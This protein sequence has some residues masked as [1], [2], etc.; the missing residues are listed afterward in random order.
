MLFVSIK[1]RV[2]AGPVTLTN[3]RARSGLVVTPDRWRDRMS[4]PHSKYVRDKIATLPFTSANRKY[5]G[6][7]LQ[8]ERMALHGVGSYLG[9]MLDYSLRARYP[10]EY[11]AIWRELNPAQY[12]RAEQKRARWEQR[13]REYERRE[14][15]REQRQRARD[16][17]MWQRI[18]TTV[19]PTSR[20]EADAAPS[21][22]R[23]RKRARPSGS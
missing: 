15:A 12:E 14:I 21:E 19:R 10:T 17:E 5:V 18:S 13:R 1:T 20:S 23:R 8:I 7:L 2:G 22:P 3:S 16:R 4:R 11:A 9:G 6:D